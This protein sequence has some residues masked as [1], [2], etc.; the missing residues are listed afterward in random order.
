MKKLFTYVVVLALAALAAMVVVRRR[1]EADL[2]IEGLREVP[3]APV[4]TV[5]EVPRVS[6]VIWVTV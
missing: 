6:S 3:L 4:P 1:A 2:P 5:Q